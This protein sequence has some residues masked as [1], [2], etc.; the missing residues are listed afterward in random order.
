M[1]DNTNRTTRA[2]TVSKVLGTI[3]LPAS[4]FGAA[5]FAAQRMVATLMKI[6][7]LAMCRP[8]QILVWIRVVKG[9]STEGLGLY[10][11][12]SEALRQSH[13]EIGM[14]SLRLDKAILDVKDLKD[15]P[16]LYT[17]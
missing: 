10:V 2:L 17:K 5:M 12:R 6:E 11:P 15:V 9:G 16:V 8:T 3:G 1:M 13:Q 4:S 14:I 7:L